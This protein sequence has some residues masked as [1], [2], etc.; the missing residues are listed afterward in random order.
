MPL[1]PLLMAVQPCMKESLRIGLNTKTLWLMRGSRGGTGFRTPPPE[2]SQ[3]YRVSL[4]YWSGSAENK[5]LPSQHLML[6]HHRPTPVSETPFKWRFTGGPMMAR[7]KCYWDSLS[8]HR[9][10]T[11]QTFWIRAWWLI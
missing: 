4:Q 11:C 10:K 9:K 6:G 7:F 2:K 1:A 5:K 3:K 8:P